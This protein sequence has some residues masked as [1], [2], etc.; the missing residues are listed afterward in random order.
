MAIK[1]RVLNLER[2]KTIE[3]KFSELKPQ[4]P[5]KEERKPKILTP[6]YVR[7]LNRGLAYRLRQIEATH[8]RTDDY[9]LKRTIMR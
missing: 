8:P 2:E 9:V 7:E 1:V 6:E 5:S 4:E 3:L